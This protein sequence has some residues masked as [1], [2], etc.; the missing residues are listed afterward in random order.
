MRYA[1]FMLVDKEHDGAA[2]LW[3][4]LEKMDPGDVVKRAGAGYE[5]GT[6]RLPFLGK[7]YRIN[8]SSRAIDE[9]AD[10]DK[11]G[12][13]LE[14]TLLAYLVLSSGDRLANEWISEKDL[15]GGSMFFRGPH[16]IPVQPLVQAFGSDAEAFSRRGAELGGVPAGFGDASVILQVLPRIPISFV[17]W[18]GDDEFPAAVTV[19][20]DRSIERCYPLD[21]VLALVSSTVAVFVSNC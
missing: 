6:Y 16:A 8:V 5:E 17:L 21:V 3:S 12:T 15:P 11:A 20:F 19:M 7:T 4:D 18:E 13:N 10:S 14:L 1:H 9:P 2:K